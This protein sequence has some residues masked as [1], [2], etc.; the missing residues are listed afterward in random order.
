M[1]AFDVACLC[2]KWRKGKAVQMIQY[3]HDHVRL[4]DEELVDFAIACV[5]PNDLLHCVW[6]VERLNCLVRGKRSRRMTWR[7]VV[8]A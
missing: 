7:V 6:A 5:Q 3:T 1:L 2:R 8:R 4:I